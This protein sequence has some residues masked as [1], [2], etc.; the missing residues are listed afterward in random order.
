M[1]TW[2]TC[3]CVNVGRPRAK[4]GMLLLLLLLLPLLLVLVKGD[5]SECDDV[6]ADD[7]KVVCC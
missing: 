1:P 5:V 3:E 4:L 7:E 6:D 2:S